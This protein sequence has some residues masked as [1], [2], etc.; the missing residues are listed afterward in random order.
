[1]YAHMQ[2][3][4]LEP[5]CA[6]GGNIGDDHDIVAHMHVHVHCA[7]SI[8]MTL[9]GCRQTQWHASPVVVQKT[10]RKPPVQNSDE[11]PTVFWATSPTINIFRADLDHIKGR[12]GFNA[13]A[14]SAYAQL[15]EQTI[16]GW[17]ASASQGG[18]FEL[19]DMMALTHACGHTCT[20]NGIHY[21]CD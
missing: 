6:A 10:S 14:L 7:Q 8:T 16:A 11:K 9:S 12:R 19:L 13:P 17:K 1:M 15:E 5:E 4:F 3:L 18:A 2:G 21:R 20:R